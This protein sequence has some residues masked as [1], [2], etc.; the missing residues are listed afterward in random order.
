VS[1]RTVLGTE[2][3]DD[4]IEVTLAIE[5]PRSLDAFGLTALFP[6]QNVR[7]LRVERTPYTE[8][9]LELAA[10]QTEAGAVRIGGFNPEGITRA[11]STPVLRV[12]LSAPDVTDTSPIELVG[13]V[14][15]LANARVVDAGGGGDTPVPG[16]FRLHQNYPNPFNPETSIRFDVPSGAGATRTRL[17]IY[18]VSGELVRVLVDEIRP[19]GF[20]EARWDGTNQHGAPVPSGVYFYS[21]EAGGYR[22][23]RRMVLLK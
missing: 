16:S 17:A 4:I 14:D 20:Y 6:P 12:V 3:V 11:G 9:W 7:F 22:T 2:G 23:S 19:P 13:F 5:D 10:V 15:D 1:Q 21:L 8:D 18:S